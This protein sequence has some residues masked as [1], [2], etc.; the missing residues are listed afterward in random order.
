M[1]WFEWFGLTSLACVVYL[2]L[3]VYAFILFPLSKK[4]ALALASA[5]QKKTESWRNAKVLL[6][7]AQ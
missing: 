1:A 2:A 7:N 5:A 3:S 4:S 6:T